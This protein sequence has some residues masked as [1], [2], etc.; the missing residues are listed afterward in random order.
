MFQAGISQSK[1][2]YIVSISKCVD[3]LKF[4]LIQNGTLYGG[5]IQ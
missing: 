4:W 3:V 1:N 5:Q 2:I